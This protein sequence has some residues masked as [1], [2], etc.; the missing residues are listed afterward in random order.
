LYN[1]F[2]INNNTEYRSLMFGALI[3]TYVG[4]IL[5]NYI[6]ISYRC[7]Q[8]VSVYLLLMIELILSNRRE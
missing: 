5:Q 8:T 7:K 1:S 3:T 4:L 2:S 6:K